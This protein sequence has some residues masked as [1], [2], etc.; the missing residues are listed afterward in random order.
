MKQG[1]V[2]SKDE[3]FNQCNRSP[4]TTH[5]KHNAHNELLHWV[6]WRAERVA[7]SQ[8]GTS[9]L[10]TS[11]SKD[12]LVVDLYIPHNRRMPLQAE[13]ALGPISIPWEEPRIGA[14]GHNLYSM[15]DSQIAKIW[16]LMYYW[17]IQEFYIPNQ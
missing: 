4:M 17:E 8:H 1:K 16:G 5:H 13:E 11:R 12:G 9:V 6:L 3:L 15:Q 2:M 14:K 7:I 10:F